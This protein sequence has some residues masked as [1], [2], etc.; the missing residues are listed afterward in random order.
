MLKHLQCTEETMLLYIAYLDVKGLKQG[1][2][3][4]YLAALHS[5]HVE[6]G[7]QY[8]FNTSH[9]LNMI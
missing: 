1:S 6:E 3:V 9:E 7:Y 2:I 5:I 8:E 4:V